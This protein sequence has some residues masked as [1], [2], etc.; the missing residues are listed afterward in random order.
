MHKRTNTGG[1]LACLDES[2]GLI[3]DCLLVAIGV[4][5]PSF[6]S[7]EASCT[8]D[9]LV[10]SFAGWCEAFPDMRT[11][12]MACQAISII[13]IY[14]YN[15]FSTTRICRHGQAKTRMTRLDAYRCAHTPPQVGAQQ[16]KHA[17]TAHHAHAAHLTST[18]APGCQSQQS[19]SKV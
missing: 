4:A 8:W 7:T 14:I 17:S 3:S 6:D 2:E 15:I 16:Q 19:H 5:V 18:V 10:V 12:G 11:P 9:T 1:S 13:Y